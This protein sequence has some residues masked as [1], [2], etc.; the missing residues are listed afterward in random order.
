MYSGA[1]PAVLNAGA[2]RL[3]VPWDD[4]ADLIDSLS[5]DWRVLDTFSACLFL[6]V[7]KFLTCTALNH[8]AHLILKIFE[9]F[10]L[11]S[12]NLLYGIF[13]VSN[14]QLKPDMFY[15]NKLSH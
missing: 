10:I 9:S 2:L 3:G 11:N 13:C 4:Q 6:S 8:G 7:E 15:E 5:A 14:S 12:K 1:L